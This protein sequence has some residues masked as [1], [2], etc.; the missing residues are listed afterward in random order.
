MT[1]LPNARPAP[2]VRWSGGPAPMRPPVT[3]RAPGLYFA[4]VI[5]FPVAPKRTEWRPPSR[6]P[7]LRPDA[8]REYAFLARLLARAGLD[9]EHYRA[10]ALL[11]RIPAC[12]RF[13]GV[14]SVTEASRRLL[15]RPALFDRL[16]GVVLLGV[17]EFCRDPAVFHYLQANVL[18]ELA[19]AHARPRLWSA[20]CSE[21]QELYSIAACLAEL[22]LLER[23]ELLGTDCRPEAIARAR[24]GD[25][26][27]EVAKS[28]SPGWRRSHLLALSG[29]GAH[30][31]APPRGRRLARA[32][33]ARRRRGRP[34][35]PD[36]LPQCG[37]LPRASRGG[38]SLAPA[39]RPAR[40]RRLSCN[41]QGRERRAP[42]VGTRGFLRFSPP[43]N[44][45]MNS[46]PSLVR[47]TVVVVLLT[48]FWGF[49]R[50]AVFAETILPLTY[51]IPLLIGV[52]TR[53]RWQNW[54]MAGAFVMFTLYKAVRLEFDGT[55]LSQ[56]ELI[57][58]GATMLNIVIGAAIVH[59]VIE[60][61]NRLDVQ[62]AR[63]LAQ[64]SELEAQTEEL[65]QQNEEI[66]TQSEE[67]AQQ[68]EEIQAQAEEL[69]RQNDELH[70]SNHRLGIRELMLQDLL[71]AARN[72]DETALASV[73]RSTLAI[74][75]TPA[76]Q[77]AILENDGP[78]RLKLSARAADGGPD[79]LPA[80]WPLE[81]S[82]AGL[83]M[84]EDR[85]AYL[86][87]F[88]THPKLAAPFA[89]DG[90]VRSLLATPLRVEGQSVG[91][92]AVCSRQA[93]H[94]T[95][96]Q[97]Q[98]LEWI[99]A[100]GGHLTRGIRLRRSL[101]TPHGGAR[102]GQPGEGRVP[103]HALPRAPHAPDA[104]AGRGRRARHRPAAAGGNPRGPR[105]DPAQRHHPEPPD[106]RPAR[107]DPHRAPQTR[108]LP[109]TLRARPAP[110]RRRS[111]RGAGR[112]R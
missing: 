109:P 31:P 88:A 32:R 96:E 36:P 59:L 79:E 20:A 93:C 33:P 63:I 23:C 21:G 72:S 53:R 5:Q 42:G 55:P 9:I 60:Y 34:V 98:L 35:A 45:P 75:G 39:G 64:N 24:L 69:V 7:V 89:P 104:G 12:L 16:L 67:L 80:A 85:T 10:N 112:R 103:R 43:E 2:G 54:A 74:I 47:S 73:C 81:H 90:P 106:R 101:A 40:A 38:R 46:R 97:F 70:Q 94:W 82:L 68:N 76:N 19:Q 1:A 71:E 56:P 87:D 8:E 28:L 3:E 83:V 44:H 111:H 108:S 52:W 48:L 50:V 29:R 62:T 102:G 18:P 27:A 78:D 13:L 91:V 49:L 37:H 77:V 14:S 100:M 25:Y 107:P 86:S 105:D 99:A 51:V 30:P 84:Q 58:L 66:R 15:E 57:V 65:T 41:R 95:D 17:S 11:R 61:R 92:L 4:G 6:P 26:P 22:D 110:A